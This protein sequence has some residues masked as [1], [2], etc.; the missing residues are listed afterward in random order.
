MSLLPQYDHKIATVIMRTNVF[1]LVISLTIIGGLL[2]VST[3]S[4]AHQGAAPQG[5]S[6]MFRQAS[7]AGSAIG[8]RINQAQAE[9]KAHEASMMAKIA[10]V[11]LEDDKSKGSTAS[12]NKNSS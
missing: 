4:A 3:V 6:E 1:L 9:Q 11:P 12:S 7:E 2:Q 5:F 10:D 8:N